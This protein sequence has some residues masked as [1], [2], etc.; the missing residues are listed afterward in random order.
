[1]LETIRISAAGY[2]SR[3]VTV[4]NMQL[5]DNCNAGYIRWTYKEFF[6]RYRM[7]LPWRRV[8]PSDVRRMCETIL[9]D[10]IKVSRFL[11]VLVW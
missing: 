4:P 6:D 2:P 9:T 5:I 1:M 3:Y 10:V 8:R 7:L 11:G